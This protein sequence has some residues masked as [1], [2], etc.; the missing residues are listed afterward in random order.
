VYSG[1]SRTQNPIP[2]GSGGDFIM[3]QN[4]P[5]SAWGKKYLTAPTSSSTSASLLQGNL[6]RIGLRDTTTQIWING[7]KIYPTIPATLPSGI[8]NLTYNSV[9]QFIQFT[10]NTGN[11]TSTAASTANSNYILADKS[12]TVAQYLGGA[13]GAGVGDPEMFYLTPL[14]QAVTSTSFYRNTLQTIDAN[15]VTV[16][17]ATSDVPKITD[18]GIATAWTYTY[19]HPNYIGKTVYVKLWTPS[20]QNQVNISADSAFTGIT[21]GLGSVESYG[22]NI[23]TLVKTL[24]ST[25]KTS[26][27]DTTSLI[28][29]TC[30]GKPFQ[31]STSVP[32]LPDSISWQL[33]TIPNIHPNTTV[34]FKKPYSP[35]PIMS[36]KTNG[37][38]LYKFTL[39][40]NYSIDS[41]GYYAYTVKFWHQDVEG[42]DKS[43]T[44]EQYVQIFPQP[45]INNIS[46][47]SPV[48]VGNTLTLNVSGDNISL[49]SWTGSNGFVSTEPNP[50]IP[51][52]TFANAGKY[53][54]TVSNG[55]CSTTDSIT[56]NIIPAGSLSI[57]GR[58]ITANKKL[59][60]NAKIN[61]NSSFQIATLS[62]AN[63]TYNF[64]SLA[65]GN[66]VLKPSKNN[67]VKKNNGVSGID[68]ILVTNHILNKAK[69]NSAYKIIAADVNNNR[70]VTNIDV[71]FMKRLIL[72]IDTTFTGNRLWAFVDSSYAF[73][74]TTNPFPFKDSISLSNLAS[75]KTNQTFIGVKLGDVNYDWNP[76]LARGS[77]VDNVSLII[78]NEKLRS[79]DNELY[80][81]IA[82]K[83]FNDLTALQYTLHFDNSKYE[84][85]AIKNNK[86]LIEYNAIQANASGDISFLWADSKGEERSFE[87][88]S[89]L[90]TL[91]LKSK[92]PVV[93]SEHGIRNLELGLLLTNDITEIEAWDK[94][95]QKHSITLT[96]NDRSQ[97][98]VNNHN[99]HLAIYPNPATN[100][101]NVS[102][103]EAK[104]I[105]I[106]DC[107]GR[108]M[109]H[110]KTNLAVSTINCKQFSKGIYMVQAILQ[111][112]SVKKEKLV[113]E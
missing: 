45:T 100:L 8:F 22:Y 78:D 54:V 35:A 73:A 34:T 55:A 42:C 51:N 105:I 40:A 69:L 106:T 19:P 68:V 3:Q 94:D 59:V 46:Y 23:G 6:F 2:C 58:V 87:N 107:V 41:G 96:K 38:T 77:S 44:S 1:S 70:T 26:T 57:D 95:N 56:V 83:N 21:Y 97:I 24:A 109:Y 79:I 89:E 104:A 18:G 47:N 113:I 60:N 49:Y 48:I 17:G 32:V 62:Q 43:V 12:I 64:G 63:G 67:D 20:A 31:I 103:K 88:G 36:V 4:F 71:I 33:N 16:I 7:I 92:L 29:T 76:A 98:A 39:P 93:N 5:A 50:S 85:V 15:V 52:V 84:F 10:S 53:Y 108:I 28:A 102:C 110:Q 72:G 65:N 99:N 112:G 9:G 66:Y 91:V 27:G 11:A 13:C 25:V 37:D 86:L 82:V 14:E 81:P 80:I 75:S 101:V 111:D 61:L 30:A 90:F 74:D